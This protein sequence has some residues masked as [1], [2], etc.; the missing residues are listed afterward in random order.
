MC[1]ACLRVALQAFLSDLNG[2]FCGCESAVERGA[3]T[4][5]DM[6]KG[7]DRCIGP[8]LSIIRDSM[9]PSQRS[10]ET[11]DWYNL[12][13]LYKAVSRSLGSARPKP[14]LTRLP[15]TDASTPRW[16][17]SHLPLEMSNLP[18]RCFP[19]YDIEERCD[20]KKLDKTVDYYKLHPSTL[21][22]IVSEYNWKVRCPEDNTSPLPPHVR[23]P[24]KERYIV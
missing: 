17:P 12:T 2:S 15:S 7:K 24:R 22:D 9:N 5:A 16:S 13:L 18:L 4:V 3:A 14:S 6:A 11:M 21:T 1:L 8:T 10:E 19:V 23:L 20:I